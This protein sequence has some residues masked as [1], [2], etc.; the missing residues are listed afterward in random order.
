MK[1][2]EKE[3]RISA[4]GLLNNSANQLD[5]D[6]L[7]GRVVE[8]GDLDVLD[9]DPGL[10]ISC[11]RDDL[12]SMRGRIVFAD[13]SVAPSGDVN[14]GAGYADSLREMAKN[15]KEMADRYLA[16]DLTGVDEFIDLYALKD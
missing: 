5:A 11:S 16:G 9:G 12:Q 6:S 1:R 13:V 15:L 14:Y 7:V 10:V 8:A 2:M 3:M 4:T